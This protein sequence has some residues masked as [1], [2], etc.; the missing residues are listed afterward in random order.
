[1]EQNALKLPA[2]F[3]TYGQARQAGFLRMKELKEKGARVVGTFCS[4]VPTE[5][6]Y[7]AGAL[8]VGL[9]AFTEE[10][11]P[12]AEAVLPRNLCPLIK[13]SYGFA[14]TD[15]CPYFYFSD[16][17]IGETTCDG[18]KKM[19]ELM[20]EIKDTY[21]MQLPHRR[22]ERALA[23][24]REEIIALQ[25]KLEDFYGIT[26]TEADIRDA[27]RRK[28]RERQVM[29]QYMELGRLDPAP[30]SGYEMG[31]R[32]DAGSFSFDLEQRCA[33]IEAR[34]AE[35]MAD[36]EAN[37]KGRPTDRPRLLVTGCPNAGVRDK[38]I[39]TVE[40]LGADVVAFDTCNG[41]REKVE[42]VDESESDVY[43]ALARKYLN[44][45]C[46]VMSPNESRR[47]YLGQMID[48]YRV[49]GVIEIIL[50]SCHTFDVESH[51]I[52]R[53]VTEEKGIPYLGI[54]T[55][56]SQSDKG[57]IGTRLAAF[58]ETIDK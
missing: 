48:D 56:Y 44:I 3:E 43:T 22:D 8:P 49:D 1:M 14:L 57:Q 29:R 36:W 51:L 58:L 12:A 7:A 11:I 10:P 23:F 24:W 20:D 18:K 42:P 21:V 55:D 40:E 27:I 52:R 2:D 53:Y 41:I 17:V 54:E 5:L 4:F 34:T 26:I 39:K 35:V 13:A 38:I 33:E 32:V 15:T 45:N 50:Q 30:L 31:T 47:T 37:Y 25:H 46:S 9:C 6:I 28:N 16:L 19:F